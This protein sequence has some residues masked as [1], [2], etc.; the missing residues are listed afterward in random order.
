MNTLTPP[1]PPLDPE[2]ELEALLPAYFQGQTTEE[3]TARVEDALRTSPP[4]QEAADEVLRVLDALQTLPR[5]TVTRSLR[6]SVHAE[7]DTPLPLRER[8]RPYAAAALFLLLAGGFVWMQA[9]PRAGQDPVPDIPPLADAGDTDAIRPPHTPAPYADNA[10]HDPH[11]HAVAHVDPSG[12]L[13]APSTE[14]SRT[15]T[16]EDT[17]DPARAAAAWLARTQRQDGSW[18]IEHYGGRKHLAVGVQGLALMALLQ[19]GEEYPLQVVRA[20]DHLQS[21]QNEDGSFGGGGARMYNHGIATLALLHAYPRYPLPGTDSHYRSIARGLAFTS[22]SQGADGGW[23]YFGT[24][25]DASNTAVTAWQILALQ[26]ARRLGLLPDDAPVLDTALAFLQR[27]AGD[28]TAVRYG[29]VLVRQQTD[30]MPVMTALCLLQSDDPDARRIAQALIQTYT[31]ADS[32]EPG[33]LDPYRMWFVGR[34]HAG[35]APPFRRALAR[36]QIEDGIDAGSIPALT[37]DWGHIGGTVYATAMNS[38]AASL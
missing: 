20:V 9:F 4:L 21:L 24:E 3:E 12:D 10:D 19:S 37:S 1:L 35:T 15:P 17:R 8:L 31:P 14:G 2:A 7:L 13:R 25:V 33:R 30:A 27:Q 23:G 28:G 34:T 32:A 29:N 18:D 16:P 11:A 5:H 38:L 36:T 26:E 22:R 6:E